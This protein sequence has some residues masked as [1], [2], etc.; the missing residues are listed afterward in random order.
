MRRVAR[1][2]LVL[3]AFA[4]PWEYSLDFGAPYGNIARLLG[5]GTAMIAAAAVIRERSFKKPCLVHAAVLA[6][7][8]WFCCSFFW[9]VAQHET[10]KHLRGYA[11]EMMLVWLV[12]EL[13]ADSK[14]LLVLLRSWLAGTFVLAA[15]TITSLIL[16]NPMATDQVRFVAITQDPNDVAR[17][18]AY[19]FPIAMLLA[20][21]PGHRFERMLWLL[22]FPIGFAAVLLTASRGGFLVAAVALASCA[23]VALRRHTT[24]ALATGLL[25]GA[26]VVVVLAVA[27]KGTFNRLG[28]TAELWQSGDL[29]QRVNIWS[30]GWKAFE[31]APLFGHGAGSFVVAAEMAPEDTAHNTVVSI[32]VEDGL[33]GLA[34]AAAIVALTVRAI[35]KTR[36]PLRSAL[37]ILMLVWA[38]S[39]ITGT[40][41]ENRVTWLLFGVA[42]I[43]PGMEKAC[44]D[45]ATRSVQDNEMKVTSI[46][47][48]I[49]HNLKT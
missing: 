14:C 35:Y 29:N 9:T 39:S 47:S 15:L 43:G 24:G 27:P 12:W 41:W 20:E 32:L 36:Q 1:I 25:V 40:V 17:Y 21:G 10:L 18:L 26:S 7:Y 5:L 44:G 38:L 19:G 28:T 48:T 11:Q 16:S 49:A 46:F 2:L 31:D 42:A 45:R 33:C 3:F 4:I 8:L 22:Y 6:L 13:V 30:A 37:T 23:A 34:L